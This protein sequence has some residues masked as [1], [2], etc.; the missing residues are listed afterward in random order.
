MKRKEINLCP[1]DCKTWHTK[2]QVSEILGVSLSTVYNYVSD[3]DGLQVGRLGTVF[4][5]WIKEFLERRPAKK[6]A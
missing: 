1:D 3:P 5:P 6:L 4:C 2:E